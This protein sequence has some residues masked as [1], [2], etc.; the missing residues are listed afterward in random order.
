MGCG[1]DREQYEVYLAV[2]GNM[3]EGHDKLASILQE[4]DKIRIINIDSQNFI[5][6]HSETLENNPNY[7]HLTADLQS[8]GILFAL[9]VQ[10]NFDG[11]IIFNSDNHI[12]K[13]EELLN[14]AQIQWDNEIS[15]KKCILQD[16]SSEQNLKQQ[17]VKQ[18]PIF[19]F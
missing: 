2:G 12:E 11:L 13:Y 3:Q 18:Y 1:A 16:F 19:P 5:S 17:L 10:H 8:R 7:R 15:S 6:Q 4:S 14:V 9:F